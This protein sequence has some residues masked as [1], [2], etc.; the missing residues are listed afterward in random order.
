MPH[1]HLIPVLAAVAFAPGALAATS[2]QSVPFNYDPIAGTIELVIDGFDTQGGTRQLTS[3]GFDFHHN[4]S[5]DMFVES[6][7][8][9]ALAEGDYSIGVSFISIFQ[10]GTI[11]DGGAGERGGDGPPGPPFFGPGAFFIDNQSGDLAAYDGV[12][13]NDGPDSFRRSFSDAYTWSAIFEPG[14]DQPVI[15]ALTDV[16][17]LTTIYGG[18]LEL[19][20]YWNNDPGW[21]LPPNFFPEYPTDAAIWVSLENFRHSGEIVITYEYAEVPA[22]ATAAVTLGSLVALRRRRR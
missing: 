17:S 12:P 11:D 5:V 3:V 1:P 8:P 18:F 4:F 15:D 22:P 10:L 7:G 19:G 2:S 9:T 13:G 21:P 20:F 16:G 6:T 14:A